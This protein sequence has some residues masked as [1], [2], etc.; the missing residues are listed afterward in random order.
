MEDDQLRKERARAVQRLIEGETPQAICASLKRSKAW[1]YKWLERYL[2]GG[3]DW[4]QGHSHRPSC[5]P[6]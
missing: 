4:N 3:E 1:L 5:F 2:T 6:R